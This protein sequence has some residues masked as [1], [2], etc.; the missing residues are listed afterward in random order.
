MTM[1]LRCQNLEEE[2][3]V[4]ARELDLLVAGKSTPEFKLF[5]FLVDIYFLAFLSIYIDN[6][7][8]WRMFMSQKQ[9]RALLTT[10]TTFLS[11]RFG[12]NLSGQ[13][14]TKIFPFT[15]FILVRIKFKCGSGLF[16]NVR[17]DQSQISIHVKI[18]LVIHSYS[19][20]NSS[21]VGLIRKGG[22]ENLI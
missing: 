18:N 9:I 20:S 11:N 2:G 4:A 17:M 14:L 21:R 1:L 5:G 13:N 19:S 16:C 7:A 15:F 22:L 8:S 10:A 3:G 12:W 6:N